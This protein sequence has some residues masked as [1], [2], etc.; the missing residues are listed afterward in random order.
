MEKQRILLITVI[1]SLISTALILA[2]MVTY[3]PNPQSWLIL[4]F[5]TD[6][7]AFNVSF[8]ILFVNRKNG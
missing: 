1:A 4:L 5:L 3:S 2:Y 8:G 7:F 6:L